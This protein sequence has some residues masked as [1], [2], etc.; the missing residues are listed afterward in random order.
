MAMKA[1][2][3]G[4]RHGQYDGRNS[5]VRRSSNERLWAAATKPW[6]FWSGVMQQSC[7]R[8]GIMPQ[9]ADGASHV[10]TVESA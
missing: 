1:H 6:L 5:Q 10:L 3:A 8:L 7:S 2:L 9:I 4:V